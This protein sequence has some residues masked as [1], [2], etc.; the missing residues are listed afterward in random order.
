M[1]DASISE[2][3]SNTKWSRTHSESKPKLSAST[4]PSSTAR[5]LAWAPKCGINNPNR[6]VIRSSQPLRHRMVM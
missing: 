6:M 2:W 1:S 5:R 4:A 3:G